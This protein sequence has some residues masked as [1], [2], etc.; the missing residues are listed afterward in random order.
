MAGVS[1]DPRLKKKTRQAYGKK[2]RRAW[3]AQ[4]KE[5]DD[6]VLPRA[7]DAAEGV[8]SD[9]GT[10]PQLPV[11][12]EAVPAVVLSPG[13]SCSIFSGD[14]IIGSPGTSSNIQDRV[15]TMF[16]SAEETAER[17]RNAADLKETLASQCA[18][19]R[20]FKL[21]DVELEDNG[22]E[23]GTEF[24][25]VDIAVINSLF[26]L[27]VC[28]ECGAKSMTFS[29]GKKDYGLCSKLV[30]SCSDC[31]FR[32]DR[33]SSP[34]VA[35]DSEAKI[36]PFEVNLRAMKAISSIGK[37]ATALS[38]FFAAM[39]VSHRGLHHKTF[40]SHMKTMQK[41][42]SAT[43]TECEGASVACIKDLYA[44]LG[45]AP[46]NIDVIYDGTWLTRGHT[47]HIC[48]GCIIEM[49]T[50]LVI[51]HVVLSNFCLGCTLG[52]KEND[53]GYAA[54][55]VDHAPVCQRNIDCKAGQMEVEAALLL[56]QRS[57]EKHKLRYTTMLSDGDSKTYHA[58]TTNE[59]YGYI[60]VAK[61]DCI[62]HVHK[63]M[64]AALRTLSD[65]KK[66]QGQPLGG[67]GRLT[68]DKIK[69]IPPTMVM[70]CAV[71]SM[72]CQGCRRLCWPR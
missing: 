48:V 27:V 37:G 62:N 12:A 23:N 39:N 24:S 2:K 35:G 46:G 31:D 44:E 58:L 67:K 68:Q 10:L 26:G 61:K 52:P 1:G 56:F 25:I 29:R 55:L 33:F 51:D 17:A 47:S 30:L 71:T 8:L 11:V 69:K 7:P 66:A 15:D 36:R 45:N 5:G 53:E 19:E 6:I 9:D 22:K 28:P 57:L 49:Y 20:K 4:R 54:W 21:L 64:F 14:R 38:D 63:R 40:Q 32:E 72:M 43:A 3:N 13:P 34:R 70:P 41:A 50:G 65:K 18:T 60:K 16:F 59:V 42:C